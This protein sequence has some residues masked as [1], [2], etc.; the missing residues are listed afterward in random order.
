[1]NANMKLPSGGLSD[2]YRIS[3]SNVISSFSQGSGHEEVDAL[4]DVFMWGEG[5]GDGNLKELPRLSIVTSY[6]LICI[7][8]AYQLF[9]ILTTRVVKSFRQC[10]DVVKL[11]KASN[12]YNSK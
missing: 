6:Q 1:M 9:F 4:G 2:N 5:V 8:F 11:T 3:M 7:C 12:K 10:C